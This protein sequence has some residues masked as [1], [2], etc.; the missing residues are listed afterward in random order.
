MMASPQMPL[1]KKMECFTVFRKATPTAQVQLLIAAAQV[2]YKQMEAEL[3]EEVKSGGNNIL[4][5]HSSCYNNNFE[6]N[7]K[8]TTYSSLNKRTDQRSL[9]HRLSCF[10]F[11][12]N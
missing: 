9:L 5:S 4:T 10:L 2:E 3:A 12:S 7:E 1:S 11:A 6:T 8:E